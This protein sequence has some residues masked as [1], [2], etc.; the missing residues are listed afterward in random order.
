MSKEIHQFNQLT[1]NIPIIFHNLRNYDSHF[2]M[3]EI[4]KIAKYYTY[5]NKNGEDK[6]IG[7]MQFQI[8]WKKY[9]AFMLGKHLVFIDSFQFMSSS[10]SNLLNNLPNDAF[11]YTSQIYK[12]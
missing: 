7:I 9:M 2:I 8:I 12:N 4:G 11:K 1:D 5:K 6:Q 10:L 3:Q